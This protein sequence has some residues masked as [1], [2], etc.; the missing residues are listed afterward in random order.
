MREPEDGCPIPVFADRAE[1]VPPGSCGERSFRFALLR[2]DIK[3]N[4]IFDL[5]EGKDTCNF[6][7]FTPNSPC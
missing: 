3:K 4:I 1:M 7:K 6:K 2:G 5:Q